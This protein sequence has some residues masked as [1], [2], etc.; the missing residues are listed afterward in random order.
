MI[1][2]K[3][4]K[5][6]I[7]RM[8]DDYEWLELDKIPTDIVNPLDNPDFLLSPDP[9]KSTVQLMLNED[10]LHFV[11]KTVLNVELFPF[12]CAILKTMWTHQLPMLVATRGGSKTTML[13][14]YSLLRMIL[15]PGCK[16]VA[17]G[18]AFRQSK[19][20]FD[21][22]VGIWEKAPVLRDIAG[23][24]KGCGPR[25]DIDRV[26]FKIG[27]SL[28]TGIPIGQGEKIRGMRANIV[29]VDE[30]ASIPE[31]I[32][33]IV[34]QGFGAVSM[35]LV[36]KV[37]TMATI[38]KLKQLGMWTDEMQLQYESDYRGNQIVLA[39]TAFYSF[40]HFYKD[41]IKWRSII[42]SKGDPQKLN[43]II[44]SSDVIS[45]G[46]N[47]KDYAIIRLPY[48]E[49]PEGFLDQT[50]LAQAKGTQST[51]QF[52][53]EFCA[54]FATDTKGFFRRSVLEAATTTKSISVDGDSVQFTAQRQGDSGY[55]YV[56]GIDPAADQDNAAIVLIELHKSHR[57]I[58]YCWTVNKK[59]FNK[60]K[61]SGQ[62]SEDNY[63]QYIAK[64]VRSLM[65]VF[66]VE[67]IVID[68]N[69]G[70]TAIVEMLG[71]KTGL[72]V[73]EHPIYPL[74]SEDGNLWTDQEEGI[75]IIEFIAPNTEINSAA[76]HGML[77]DFQERRLL[78]PAFDTVE[79]AKA[80]ELDSINHLEFDTYEDLIEEIEEL[81]NEITT[82][83]CTPTTKLGLEHF[84]TPEIKTE[85]NK[86]GRL[87]KD[88]YS[89]LLYANYYARN[90]DFTQPMTVKYKAVGGNK[91]SFKTGEGKQK[92]MYTGP[93]MA[94]FGKTTWTKSP[95]VRVVRH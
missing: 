58:V 11:A 9:V 20:I 71:E 70:G 47:W 73:G 39:G 5:K 59:I 21:Y 6:E 8:Q 92:G 49:L 12:Q 24:G 15:T 88:R 4:P 3:F 64:K 27:D 77:K 85:N 82:I 94:K 56:M 65:S 57:R 38:N 91:D 89:A 63:Y 50:I 61:K 66:N 76:N 40:N 23:S 86:K 44:D 90:K 87:R 93:G 67:R 25:R 48:T 34:I 68:K 55:T 52:M 74:I 33:N 53:M 46:F 81:K 26:E 51:G 10:Y 75:H 54:T 43:E 18:S 69:G 30:K 95:G 79:V 22:M 45:K 36:D 16:I 84:D 17:A 7:V 13:G 29:I 62:A 31:A 14:I 83:V 72:D 2:L 60:L 19:Q 35:D 78:F 37:K 32:F 80:F 42:L 41:F 28:W 1:D